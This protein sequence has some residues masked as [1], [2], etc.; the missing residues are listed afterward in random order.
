MEIETL[1]ETVA[2]KYPEALLKIGLMA[3]KG[4]C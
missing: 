3:K 2:K 1:G 4:G